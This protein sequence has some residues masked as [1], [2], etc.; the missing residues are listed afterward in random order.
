[1]AYIYIIHN[2]INDKKYI[3]KTETT[4][5][6]RF[7]QHLKDSQKHR[8][9]HRPLYNAINKYG[10]EHFWIEEIEK[11]S[12]EEA[13]EREKYWIE[14]YNTYKY[15]YNATLGGDGR[16]Y[17]DYNKILDLYDN[18]RKTQKEI[19]KICDCHCDTVAN[20]VEQYRNNID[21]SERSRYKISKP[22]QCI[23]TGQ[24]FPSMTEAAR[25]LAETKNMSLKVYGHIGQVCKGRRKTCGGYHWRYI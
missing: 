3:G 19:A 14:F 8:M 18:T 16:S 12:H 10:Q 7:K 11:C 13:V 15:G 17:I 24:I 25:W 2:D 1:M 21:W 5:E 20:I 6:K 4:I 23:E 22:V 9:N